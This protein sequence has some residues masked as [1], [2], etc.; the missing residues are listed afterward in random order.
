MTVTALSSPTRFATSTLLKHPAE[1]TGEGMRMLLCN[2]ESFFERTVFQL[3]LQARARAPRHVRVGG[4]GHPGHCGALRRMGDRVN[5]HLEERIVEIVT[6]KCLDCL[7]HEVLRQIVESP[8]DDIHAGADMDQ[9]D[10]GTLAARDADRGM[11]RDGVPDDLSPLG[12]YALIF[13][14]RVGGVGSDPF[15]TLNAL[16]LCG[17]SQVMQHRREKKK[18]LVIA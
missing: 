12:V 3:T 18:L 4:L 14:E 9:R 5:D 11:K 2:R 1:P 17:K 6:W 8:S 15:E 13:E 10:L 16:E 7:R